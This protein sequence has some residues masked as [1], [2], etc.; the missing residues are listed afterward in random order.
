[1]R[2]LTLNLGN[3]INKLAYIYTYFNT[4]AVFEVLNLIIVMYFEANYKE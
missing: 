4:A 3:Y 2:T 1:M